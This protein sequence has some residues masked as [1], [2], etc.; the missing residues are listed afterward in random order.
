VRGAHVTVPRGVLPRCGIEF[1][2]R[3]EDDG[4]ALS[5]PRSRWRPATEQPCFRYQAPHRLRTR[6]LRRRQSSRLDLASRLLSRPPSYR[7]PS[8]GTAA[9]RHLRYRT[10]RPTHPRGRPLHTQ[11][12]IGAIC[13]I[14]TGTRSAYLPGDR[15]RLRARRQQATASATDRASAGSHYGDRIAGHALVRVRPVETI[16]MR[17]QGTGQFSRLRRPRSCWTGDARRY[18]HVAGP[19]PIPAGSCGPTG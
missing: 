18:A 19:R 11:G 17:R 14:A 1:L 2:R 13:A 3:H 6:Q 7:R 8:T 16:A 9:Q 15:I 5:A 4:L 12:L 10:A